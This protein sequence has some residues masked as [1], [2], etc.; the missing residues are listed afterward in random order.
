MLYTGLTSVT[1]RQLPAIEIIELAKKAQL[2]TIEWGG[3]V[4]VPPD[5]LS[6]ASKIARLTREAGLVVSSYGSYWRGDDISSF[7]PVLATAQALAAPVIRIWAGATASAALTKEKRSK[8]VHNLAEATRI[9][10]AEN[11]TVAVE[12]HN[13]TLTDSLDSTKRLLID[14]ADVGLKS[15]WQPSFALSVADNLAAI[16]VIAQRLANI[17]VFSWLQTTRLPLADHADLWQQ[18]INALSQ[19]QGDRYMLLEFVKNDAPEQFIEDAKVLKQ[20][21]SKQKGCY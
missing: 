16:Q 21:L 11:I 18:Y 19:I 15:Y 1:F 13:D 20:W 10:K 7:R 6:N 17:H 3:D 2:D 5:N 8:L 12:Y 14:T 9:A 4:H